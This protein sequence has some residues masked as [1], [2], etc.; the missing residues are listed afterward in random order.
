MTRH[1]SEISEATSST[2]TA[3]ALRKLTFYRNT[4]VQTDN[5][6]KSFQKVLSAMRK[7]R[8]VIGTKWVKLV[9]SKKT[10]KASELR[11]K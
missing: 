3:S 7:I 8:D 5:C 10:S 2:D 11:C 6:T 1:S 9:Y 4:T